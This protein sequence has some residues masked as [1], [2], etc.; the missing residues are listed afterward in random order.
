M[1]TASDQAQHLLDAGRAGE[2]EACAVAAANA[3]DGDAAWLLALWRL[4]GGGAA[5]RDLVA[6]RGWLRVG[7]EA[8]R[9]DAALCEAARRPA[10]TTV[11][12]GRSR[13]MSR[14]SS[15]SRRSVI[16]DR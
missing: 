5:G 2:A 11:Q 13:A 9:L 14:T 15:T 6:A 3:G 7:R 16:W 10:R 4:T 12:P 8:G 1:S